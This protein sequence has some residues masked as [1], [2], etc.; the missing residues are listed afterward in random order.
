MYSA[1]WKKSGRLLRTSPTGHGLP[2][3]YFTAG[4]VF[5]TADPNDLSA[6]EDDDVGNQEAQDQQN[7]VLDAY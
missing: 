1:E 4:M 6:V 2:E 3:P 7:Q 5:H